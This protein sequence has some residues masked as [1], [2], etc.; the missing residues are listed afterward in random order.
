MKFDCKGNF[1]L[2]FF[3]VEMKK[4]LPNDPQIL[5]TYRLKEIEIMTL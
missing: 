1:P 4:V 5:K 3:Y 2:Q